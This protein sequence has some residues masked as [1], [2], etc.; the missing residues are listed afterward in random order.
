MSLGGFLMEDSKIYRNN[1][2]Q[3]LYKVSHDEKLSD[4][5][6]E[7]YFAVEI[8]KHKKS[9][10][11]E[12]KNGYECFK[13]VIDIIFSLLALIPTIVLIAILSIF[14]VIDSKGSPIFT[15]VRVGK[16]GK[17]IKI[18]K[19]RSMDINAELEGQQWATDDDPRVTKIGRIL[20]KYRLDEIPQFFSVLTGELSLIGPRP[21]TP[22]LTKKFNEETPGF[23][24]RLL[25]TPGMSGWAQINGGYDIS[26]EE[27]LKY[28]N[29]YIEN[30]SVKM[31]LKIFLNTL[32]VVSK[33]EGAK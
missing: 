25:V 17:L 7:S 32:G 18:R 20:R 5:D 8:E 26:Y 3:N 10:K 11:Y 19:L 22:L 33:G 27:K 21:E 15:Q 6:Y 12:K 31:Y 28:D 24:T 1:E 9:I 2:G 4:E 23:V 29:K 16:N 30:R 13:R 14:I